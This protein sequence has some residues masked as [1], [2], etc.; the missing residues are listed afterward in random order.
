MKF[1][2]H[3]VFVSSDATA[4]SRGG[5]QTDNP[6]YLLDD[7]MCD[8]N[9]ASLFDCSHAGFDLHNC[10]LREEAGVICSMCVYL[11][12][13]SRMQS[14]GYALLD[15]YMSNHNVKYDGDSTTTTTT[16]KNANTELV[17]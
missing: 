4:T 15:T 11:I 7:V 16:T 3:I 10:K 6:M 13:I 5:I 9:E 14:K 12:H 17:E 2:L 8:G 1:T